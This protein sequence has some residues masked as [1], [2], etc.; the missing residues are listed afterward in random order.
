MNGNC[1]FNRIAG[2]AGGVI[3]YSQNRD[4]EARG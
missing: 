4:K 2:I 1:K 3:L